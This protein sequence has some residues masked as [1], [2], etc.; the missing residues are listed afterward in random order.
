M[1]GRAPALRRADRNFNRSYGGRQVRH[2]VSLG[3]N[4]GAARSKSKRKVPAGAW[5]DKLLAMPDDGEIGRYR[6]WMGTPCRGVNAKPR[7]MPA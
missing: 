3:S 1:G 6:E 7:R 2:R 4:S 5:S